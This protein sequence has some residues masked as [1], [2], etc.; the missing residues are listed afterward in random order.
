MPSATARWR[1]GEFGA[2]TS[3]DVDRLD[4]L[5]AEDV[6]HHDPYDPFAADGL[7]GLKASINASRER[8]RT[9]EIRVLDQVAE[10]DKV[11]T[12]WRATMTPA[13]GAEATA[14]PPREVSMDG[15]T[16]ERFANG[17]VV[18][19]WRSMDRLGLLHDLDLSRRPAAEHP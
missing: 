19:A 9:L 7:E 13:R 12:R 17:R 10:G 6:I 18:E 4:D 3:C 14:G 16:I 15:I 11:A 8:F 2:W 5:V 1:V